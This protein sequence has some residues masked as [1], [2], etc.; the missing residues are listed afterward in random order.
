MGY[1][2]V[3]LN[4]FLKKSCRSVKCTYLY[5]PY[6][7]STF[8]H[9]NKNQKKVRKVL[10]NQKTFLLLPPQI[11]ETFFK[12]GFENWNA[13]P[14]GR[15]YKHPFFENIENIARNNKSLIPPYQRMR[16]NN[17]LRQ[18][19]IPPDREKNTNL[20]WRVWSWLRINASGRPNTC[21]SRGNRGSN[22]CWRPAHGCV[23]RL[24][25]SF[26]WGIAP[27]NRD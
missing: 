27:R 18:L 1:I 25:P 16:G 11:K 14:S 8:F 12:K 6:E 15:I 17:S 26:N 5:A 9:R 13:E 22:I 24:Q 19:P 4:L 3:S 20:Q 10:Q 23:T 7:S 2:K 21:K